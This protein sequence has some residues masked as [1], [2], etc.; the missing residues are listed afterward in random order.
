MLICW[1]CL[2][3]RPAFMMKRFVGIG[4]LGLGGHSRGRQA[5]VGAAGPCNGVI[6]GPDV[7]LCKHGVSVSPA[8]RGGRQVSGLTR[9]V[10]GCGSGEAS[11][12]SGKESVRG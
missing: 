9:R 8:T 3:V 1:P 6:L 11:P 7:L 2:L 10:Y 12:R 4:P 5:A